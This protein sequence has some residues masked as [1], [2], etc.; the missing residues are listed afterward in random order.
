MIIASNKGVI[1]RAADIISREEFL[2][3]IIEALGIQ[4]DLKSEHPYYMAALKQKII[5]KETFGENYQKPLSK[6]DA[7]VVLVRADEYLW[8]N[9]NR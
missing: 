8:K 7:A 1:L 9:S 3:M 5:T 4:I 6:S 2:E